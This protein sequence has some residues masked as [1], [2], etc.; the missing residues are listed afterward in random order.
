MNKKFDI[1]RLGMV[2]SWDLHTYWKKYLGI[3]IGLAIAIS[4]FYLMQLHSLSWI[5]DYHRCEELYHE[6]F[7]NRMSGIPMGFTVFVFFGL[8]T[9]IFFNMKSKTD[10]ANFLMLP[11]SNIEKF[12]ARLLIMSVGGIVITNVASAIADLVQLAFS[13]YMT[14]GYHDSVTIAAF[15]L[16]A[17]AGCSKPVQTLIFS[18]N[19]DVFCLAWSLII[20]F[21][22]LC[23]LGGTIYRKHPMILTACTGI[24]LGFIFTFGC[25]KLAEWGFFDLFPSFD[26]DN[27]TT[28]NC[29]AFFWSGIYLGMATACYWVSYKIFSRMQIICNKWINL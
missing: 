3:T 14:P 8:A 21:H 12:V 22:S 23:T 9:C 16:W 29:I 6:N 20:L 25:M 19:V 26:Y 27:E 28:H 1:H 11:A 4:L 18:R 24:V 7:Y 2:L 17:N 10:R 13:F 5:M 15:K